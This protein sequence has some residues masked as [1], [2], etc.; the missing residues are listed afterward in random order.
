MAERRAGNLAAELT[1]FVGR[2]DEVMAGVRLL[3]EGRLLT[4]TGPAGVG[5]SRLALRVAEAL[6]R[7]SP[8]GLWHVDLGSVRPAVAGDG[9]GR[10]TGTARQ[11]QPGDD[12]VRQA[13][14]D[15][16]RQ[17]EKDAA[18]VP[19]DAVVPP[20]GGGDP[21]RQAAT[22]PGDGVAAELV[23]VVA[24]ALGVG[25]ELRSADG[26]AR[27]LRGHRAVI[28][29]D[30]CEHVR[31]EAARLVEAL[32]LGAPRLRVLTTSRRPLGT[33]RER[34]LR[35]PPLPLPGSR[36]PDPASPSVALFAARAVAFDPEF[37]LTPKVL[38][39][40]AE[41]CR[42]LDGLPLAI[43][44][45]AAR[46]RSLATGE[47]LERLDD[48]FTLPAGAGAAAQPRHH[49]LRA[50]VAWSHDLCGADQRFL[51]TCLSTVGGDF[52][53][54]TAE[55]VVADEAGRAPEGLAAGWVGETLA[56]LA[57][58]S[59]VLADGPRYRMLETYR[60][61]G[62]D[63]RGGTPVAR[64]AEPRVD[65]RAPAPAAAGGVRIGRPVTD[66]LTPRELQIAELIAEGLSN[67]RI[68]AHLL[69]AKR[70]VD[71]HVRNILAK[72][73]LVS[74]TQVATWFA[75]RHHWADI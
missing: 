74:R 10:R 39:T 64:R 68:A 63:L 40:V 11:V 57:E 37:S 18:A 8:D 54:E 46:T 70:T 60:R 67:P 28:V 17:A 56:E 26:L 42:R 43:E 44:L 29:L 61:F 35:L 41:I 75:E 66:V 45:A 49:D 47:L 19:S 71:A 34:V 32:L 69:I 58:G 3:E 13:G 50:A 38:A 2:A 62:L 52:D 31:P 12:P 1:S 14:D 5:K 65:E 33:D 59:I 21:V 48:M 53:L 25:G 16:V 55:R 30:T 7:R 20:D 73:G 72:G 24:A 4:V 27:A 51:W 23:A 6:R 22:N 15:P 36:S 9:P